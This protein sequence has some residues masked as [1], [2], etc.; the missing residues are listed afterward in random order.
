[1]KTDSACGAGLY[2]L[3]AVVDYQLLRLNSANWLKWK[4]ELMAMGIHRPACPAI[5]TRSSEDKDW[6]LFII[7]LIRQD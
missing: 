3:Q 7:L 1:M 6:N 5:C 2:I 4:S